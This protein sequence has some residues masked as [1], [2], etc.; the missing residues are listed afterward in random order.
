MH[1]CIQ[2]GIIIHMMK[3]GVY[4]KK[5]C[6]DDD[7]YVDGVKSV[8]AGH[9]IQPVFVSKPAEIKGFEVL[10]VFGGDGT[11]LAVASECA[12]RG[13]KLIG[14]NY[15]HI[16]FLAEFEPDKLGEAADM[17]RSGN[18]ALQQRSMLKVVYRQKE[19]FALNDLVIQRCT[20]GNQFSNTITLRASIDGSVVDNYTAD[21][22]IV[23]TPTGSTAYSLA[24][25]GSVLTPDIDAFIM[26]PICAHSLHSRPVVYSDKSSLSLIRTDSRGAIN[27][28]I[29][30]VT[31]DCADDIGEITVTKADYKV[32]FIT[33]LES[34]FFNKLLIKLNIWSK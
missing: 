26:T 11:M 24:A 33:P 29:D 3:V 21:G 6:L 13:V 8:L 31:V 16:G 1:I 28:V 9:G 32:S 18:Y 2:C 27:V 7:R 10:M 25:G 15:G 22:L 34:D 20:S 12:R 30:G 4:F 14:I 17:I 23:S 19:Y 5:S